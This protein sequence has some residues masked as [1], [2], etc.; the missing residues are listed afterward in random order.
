MYL[1]SRRKRMIV[2]IQKEPHR[3]IK[4]ILLST[5]NIF[6]LFFCPLC[7]KWIGTFFYNFHANVLRTA[8][9]TFRITLNSQRQCTVFLYQS[10]FLQLCVSESPSL[11]RYRP[12]FDVCIPHWAYLAF[13]LIKLWEMFFKNKYE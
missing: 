5:N 6:Q 13:H 1:L 7:W 2:E 4:S 9:L 11:L 8:F 10:C 3:P 12:M